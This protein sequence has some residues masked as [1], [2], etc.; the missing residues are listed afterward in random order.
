M[1]TWDDLVNSFRVAMS[2]I[3]P[4]FDWGK[5]ESGKSRSTP[6]N[7]WYAILKLFEDVLVCC[8]YRHDVVVDG[9]HLIMMYPSDK[10]QWRREW[11]KISF[12]ILHYKRKY[13]VQVI[14]DAASTVVETKK[15]SVAE[16]CNF[17]RD[18]FEL[19]MDELEHYID[20]EVVPL[21]FDLGLEVRGP[22]DLFPKD[23][24]EGAKGWEIVRKV[25]EDL[26]LVTENLKILYG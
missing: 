11:Q 4:G 9:K 2:D 5:L 19:K 25:E 18:D 24:K 6:L 20:H 16:A 17:F 8:S 3:N 15:R 12:E 22:K 14:D 7:D 10:V 13:L 21:S 23:S 1:G 26:A